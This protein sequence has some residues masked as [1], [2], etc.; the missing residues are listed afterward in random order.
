MA[1]WWGRMSFT[2][3]LQL[4]GAYYDSRARAAAA[5]GCKA[6]AFLAWELFQAFLHRRAAPERLD[7]IQDDPHAVCRLRHRA[8]LILG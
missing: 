5:S 8:W 4:C 3:A 7:H 1:C 2:G 6:L